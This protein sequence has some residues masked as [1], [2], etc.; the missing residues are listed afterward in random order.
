METPLVSISFV[1]FNA[2]KYIGDAIEGCLKQV[3][4]FPY[5]IIMHDDASNDRT[6]QIILDQANKYPEMIIPIILKVLKS[7]QG[8][9]FRKL[10]ESTLLLWKLMIIGL[11]PINY[12]IK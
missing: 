9:L 5:E 4:N 8:L 11:T 12:K 7:F 1:A 3:V 10:E 6:S 2:E